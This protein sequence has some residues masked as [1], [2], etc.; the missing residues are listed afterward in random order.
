MRGRPWS[1]T[2][3]AVIMISL[4]WLSLMHVEVAGE[5]EPWAYHTSGEICSL[6][7]GLALE[8]SDVASYTTAG[9][10]LGVRN[11]TTGLE[12]PILL[13]GDF[14]EMR[15]SSLLIGGHHGDEP[16]SSESVLGFAAYL[17]EGYASGDRSAIHIVENT[18]TA[19]LPVVNPWGLDNGIRYDENGEDPNRDYPFDPS[20][21]GFY[22][23][24]IPLTTAGAS[25]VHEICRMYPFQISVSFHTG[26]FGIYTPWGAN[27]VG[28]LT[29]DLVSFNDL[30][31]TL[32][33]ASGWSI[34]Y[35]P[36]NDFPY[37]G[38]LTGAYDDHL[39]GASFLGDH[40]YDEEMIL[41][42]STHTATVEL[43]ASKGTDVNRL[44]N[45][46]GVLYPG[47]EDDGTVPAGI[48]I[49]MAA[50]ELVSPHFTA[51]VI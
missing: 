47:G 25:A 9:E 13:V 48:R 45:L 37:V 19:I 30:G 32:S 2:A 24:G 38:Y 35:G 29:P 21:S 27:D 34:P 18:N 42:W 36:A 12:I 28:N 6:L 17:L 31:H 41:P 14:D 3:L 4:S 44:G 10:L 23:D 39:Y 20:P 26:S 49:C 50:C 40:L 1:T 51:D 11:I 15:P 43:V 5:A 7:E 46:D 22:S 33:K 8:H 16:D